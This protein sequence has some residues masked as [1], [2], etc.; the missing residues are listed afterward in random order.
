MMCKYI[1]FPRFGRMDISRPEKYGGDVSY[2][3]YE[4]LSEAYF[5]GAL[6][7][8]DLKGGFADALIAY[9]APVG[10][11]FE[12]HPENYE[13]MKEIVASLKKLR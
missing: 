12:A 8:V 13:R 9:L 6:G 2:D 4:A 10:E 7:P 5:S 11:Y 1:I 3:S